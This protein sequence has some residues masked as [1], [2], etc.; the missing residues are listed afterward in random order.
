MIPILNSGPADAD[1]SLQPGGD[2]TDNNIWLNITV[3]GNDAR[4]EITNEY[5]L[6]DMASL[7]HNYSNLI[8]SDSEIDIF[9]D[10]ENP[11]FGEIS[12]DNK[13]EFIFDTNGSFESE[14]K[15]RFNATFYFSGISGINYT[16]MM[17][18]MNYYEHPDSFY[19]YIHG[20]NLYIN[21]NVMLNANN[22]TTE[23]QGNNVEFSYDFSIDNLWDS[24]FDVFNL[25]YVPEFVYPAHV[26][27]WS[28]GSENIAQLDEILSASL[29][30]EQLKNVAGLIKHEE[31]FIEVMNP[32]YVETT[33]TH[34]FMN[35]ETGE[36]QYYNYTYPICDYSLDATLVLDG[37]IINDF[38]P[39]VL[40]FPN[41][42]N[43][44]EV[45]LSWDYIDSG[46]GV[47]ISR[48]INL[49]TTPI[50]RAW[51]RVR[52]FNIDVPGFQPYDDFASDL[53][54]NVHIETNNYTSYLAYFDI[55]TIPSDADSFIEFRI[56]DNAVVDEYDVNFENAVMST[57][58]GY[59]LIR[60]SGQCD[61]YGWNSVG[62][63]DLE[64][65]TDGDDWPNYMDSY[66][67]IPYRGNNYDLPDYSEA[68]DT[69]GDGLYDEFDI[70]DDNDGI[71]DRTDA[72]PLVP[73]SDDSSNV[74]IGA[75]L[76]GLIIIV[77]LVVIIS[78]KIG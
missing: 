66:P 3:D 57:H 24:P 35:D 51:G 20:Y 73:S 18:S 11:A 71:L 63:H 69:D 49:D 39:C 50:S 32:T 48:S 72:D 15:I 23:K 26:I 47:T 42:I 64:Y 2:I 4:I 22:G 8:S 45:T 77:C 31:V 28:A 5:I 17:S 67:E 56:Y 33:T 54:M 44:A 1:I 21:S 14:T 7:N 16:R 65:D 78:K 53:V 76:M 62:W 74:T 70:D 61:D 36:V 60:F 38:A 13:F 19:S 6:L 55:V 40:W 29:T 25:Y 37:D 43:E 27:T 58:E 10:F 34:G 75:V 52:G 12:L 9:G 46:N 59:T 41:M 68:I 30:P